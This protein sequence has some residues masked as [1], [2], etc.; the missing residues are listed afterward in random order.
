MDRYSIGYDFP[1]TARPDGRVVVVPRGRNG[2]ETEIDL[3][4]LTTG[5][6][7]LHFSN[8]TPDRQAQ[9]LLNLAAY[10]MFHGVSPGLILRTFSAIDVWRDMGVLLPD[11]YFERAFTRGA[12]D[13]FNPHNP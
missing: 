5:H 13:A 11:G 3:D 4:L 1:T 12:Y 8:W 6:C 9:A 7:W 2:D 10:L